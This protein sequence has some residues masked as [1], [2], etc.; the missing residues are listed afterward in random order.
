MWA[1]GIAI[2]AGAIATVLFASAHLVKNLPKGTFNR[3]FQYR[4]FRLNALVGDKAGRMATAQK[5]MLAFWGFTLVCL[6]IT[7]SLIFQ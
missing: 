2:V 7:I 6:L 1:M 5:R 3:F 4:E